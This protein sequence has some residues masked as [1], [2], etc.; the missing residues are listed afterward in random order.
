M[1]IC[2]LSPPGA[3]SGRFGGVEPSRDAYHALPTGLL[4]V[5][6]V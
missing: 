5:P 6:G 2:E 3:P 4:S 1:K